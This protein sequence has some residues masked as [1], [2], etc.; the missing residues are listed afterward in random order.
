MRGLER[1]IIYIR[2]FEDLIIIRIGTIYMH[3]LEDCIMHIFLRTGSEQ[4]FLLTKNHLP[5]YVS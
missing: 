1:T 4:I 2:E 3:V 5:V